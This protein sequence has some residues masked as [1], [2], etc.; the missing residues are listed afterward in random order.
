M[1]GEGSFLIVFQNSRF[2][3]RAHSGQSDSKYF[4][5]STA[6]HRKCVLMMGGKGTQLLSSGSKLLMGV[7]L[8][9]LLLSSQCSPRKFEPSCIRLEGEALSCVGAAEPRARHDLPRATATC[10]ALCLPHACD[11]V[12]PPNL[13]EGKE[14]HFHFTDEKTVTPAG[15]K[16]VKHQWNIDS[17]TRISIQ[18]GLDSKTLDPP[19][20]LFYTLGKQCFRIYIRHFQGHWPILAFSVMIRQWGSDSIHFSFYLPPF[21]PIFLF[22]YPFL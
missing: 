3:G 22:K 21:L 17:G 13:L 20:I 1:P 16:F 10:Q 15:S 9:S 4:V 7:W 18:V 5:I 19:I 2:L 6:T 11:P 12:V 14:L 8:F